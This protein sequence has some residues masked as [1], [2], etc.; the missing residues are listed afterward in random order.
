MNDKA[1][2]KRDVSFR[3]RRVKEIH[4]HEGLGPIRALAELPIVLSTPMLRQDVDAVV[5]LAP[6]VEVVVLHVAGRFRKAQGV[7]QIVVLV[8]GVEDLREGSELAVLGRRRFR[9]RRERV[10][11]GQGRVLGEV[12]EPRVAGHSS[13]LNVVS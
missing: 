7:E 8:R 11:E 3:I 1:V 4:R 13:R 9:V 10:L 12:D 2:V 6:L 5:A